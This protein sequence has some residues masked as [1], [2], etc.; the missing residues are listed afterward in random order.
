MSTRQHTADIPSVFLQGLKE[1]NIGCPMA[2]YASP[3]IRSV[4]EYNDVYNA[5]LD[6]SEGQGDTLIL[7]PTEQ[8]QTYQEGVPLVQQLWLD[9]IAACRSYNMQM[10]QIIA[11]VHSQD[12]A[13]QLLKSSGAID[14]YVTPLPQ[15]D[16]V[17]SQLSTTLHNSNYMRGLGTLELLMQRP[18]HDYMAFHN[19][20]TFAMAPFYTPLI[21]GHRHPRHA[22][23]F[24][25]IVNFTADISGMVKTDR[26][27]LA[28]VREWMQAST[29]HQIYQQ[30][31][32]PPQALEAP[33]EAD[34]QRLKGLGV[35]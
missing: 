30:A 35:I 5:L 10:L 19:L 3:I 12:D 7:L 18:Q 17:L 34:I 14:T 20:F 24:S 9:L 22:P 31:V 1:G 2:K 26:P 21:P 13:A 16:P 15:L 23:A 11:Q 6:L 27:G 32:Y 29:G 8:P 28:K 4:Q 25:M 33:S